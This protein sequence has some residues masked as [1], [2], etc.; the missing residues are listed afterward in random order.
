MLKDNDTPILIVH[1]AE[2]FEAAPVESARKPVNKLLS[3]RNETF[4]YWEIPNMGHTWSSLPPKDA[5]DLER[6]MLKWL[7]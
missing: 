6:K 1:G 4:S 7:L 3:V 2:D 5:L